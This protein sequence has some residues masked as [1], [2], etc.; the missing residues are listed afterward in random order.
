MLDVHEGH[1]VCSGVRKS[2]QYQAAQLRGPLHCVLP[3]ECLNTLSTQHGS[4]NWHPDVKHLLWESLYRH[5]CLPTAHVVAAPLSLS[6]NSLY[7]TVVHV[8]DDGGVF[9]LRFMHPLPSM[10]NEAVLACVSVYVCVCD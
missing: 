7:A 6:R 9:Q 8:C 5:I 10:C 3:T 2:E 1:V 4:T